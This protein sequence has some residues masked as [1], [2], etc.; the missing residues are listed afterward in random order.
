MIEEKISNFLNAPYDSINLGKPEDFK[1]DTDIKLYWGDEPIGYL[2]KGSNIYSPKVEAL[3]SEF[4]NTEKKLLVTAKLQDWIDKKIAEELKPIKDKLD[5]SV[6]PNVRAIAFNTFDHLGT[7][8]IGE[9]SSFIKK[10]ESDDRSNISK[11]G[12]RIGAKFFFTPSF[13]KKSAMEIC[14]ILWKVYHNFSK[15]VF[16]PLPKD[17]RVSFLPET[18]MPDSYW[19]AVG[20]QCINNFALRID[21]FEKVFF[22]A[23]QKIKAGPFLES[24]DMMNPVGCNS[25]Q[26][27]D[28]LAFC[29]FDCVKLED[30]KKLFHFTFKKKVTKKF[31]KNKKTI[32]IKANNKKNKKVVEKK[33]KTDPNSPFAVLEKLL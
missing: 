31:E 24:A 6:S 16:F 5:S 21:V 28:I 12:I 11:L 8:L 15:D 10:I 19:S 18:E 3:N 2:S 26:L 30:G 13:L 7:L 33:I 25:E 27:K 29:G 23:R 4:L 20:Y 32:E 14:A 9:F 1:L 17:G 22:L